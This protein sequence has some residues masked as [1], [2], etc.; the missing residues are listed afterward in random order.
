[1][2]IDVMG[3]ADADGME[4]INQDICVASLMRIGMGLGSRS[5]PLDG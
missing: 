1:M 4:L 2:H 5:A 3:D